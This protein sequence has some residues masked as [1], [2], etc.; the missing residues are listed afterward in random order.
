MTAKTYTDGAAFAFIALTKDSQGKDQ[1]WA[2]DV[3]N[4]SETNPVNCT[5]TAT[6]KTFTKSVT[7]STT[8]NTQWAPV[9]EPSTAALALAGLALLL[10]RRKA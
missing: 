2:S 9:P 7:A 5:Y 8:I 6:S 3:F 10:K 1:Y 4:V